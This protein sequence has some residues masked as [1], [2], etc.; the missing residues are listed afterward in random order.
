MLI[1]IF[2]DIQVD[3]NEKAI[4]NGKKIITS[5]L[6]RIAKKKYGD[7]KAGATSFIEGVFENI[8]SSIKPL[9]AVEKTDLVIEAI[10]ENLSV[11][12]SLFKVR[13]YLRLISENIVF[14]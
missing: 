13:F 6:S 2:F 7:D 5:S 1:L 8:N 14:G 12:Q 9:E 3:T 4:E 11:K 10:V